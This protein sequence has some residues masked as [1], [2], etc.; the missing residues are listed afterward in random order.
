MF[1]RFL[2][3]IGRGFVTVLRVLI[4]EPVV[5]VMTGMVNGISDAIRRAMPTVIG[6]LVLW[7]TLVYFPQMIQFAILIGVMIFGL[8]VMTRS[9]LSSSGKKRKK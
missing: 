8:K 4:W 7:A 2:R 9:I 1:E 3:A 5:S 6:G